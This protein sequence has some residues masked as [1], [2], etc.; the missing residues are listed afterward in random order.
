MKYQ[1][2]V[3]SNEIKCLSYIMAQKDLRFYLN[4]IHINA[5]SARLEATNGFAAMRI[6]IAGRV[7][8][9][10]EGVENVVL[11]LMVV[12]FIVKNYRKHGT[13]LLLEIDTD[14]NNVTIDLIPLPLCNMDG[15]QYPDLNR[16]YPVENEEFTREIKCF[17]FNTA[18]I[19]DYGKAINALNKSKLT[20]FAPD[21]FDKNGQQCAY[22][23]VN[24]C[25][26]VLMG[27]RN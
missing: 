21:M 27:C 7:N 18:L 24:N 26:Y 10:G 13:E 12:D 4:G 2:T 8:D 5:K 9:L 15:V 19:N 3:F 17:G 23:V 1:V 20:I 16:V 14:K 22:C 25:D 11:P 6:D